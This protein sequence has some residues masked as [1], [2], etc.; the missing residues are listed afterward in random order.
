[1]RGR[2]L[3]DFFSAKKTEQKPGRKKGFLFGHRNHNH[4]SNEPPPGG[5]ARVS[6]ALPTSTC[7]FTTVW[8]ESVK[9]FG[10]AQAEMLAVVLPPAHQ[11]GL[12]RACA[13]GVE[14]DS[15]LI[16]R[17]F[18]P[19]V[20]CWKLM[21]AWIEAKRRAAQMLETRTSFPLRRL[22]DED[23]SITYCVYLV[24]QDQD[25]G[26]QEP[27][28][29]SMEVSRWI[30]PSSSEPSLSLQTHI[31]CIRVGESDSWSFLSSERVVCMCALQ[32]NM[33]QPVEL[34]VEGQ[35][36]KLLAQSPDGTLL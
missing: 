17:I 31:N 24:L 23:L 33:Q 8:I 22:P 6:H 16:M 34:L 32:M 1:M 36:M 7:S 3:E 27:Q 35:M 18:E 15:A 12:S 4:E 26:L 14:C 29:H 9:N 30:M 13:W 19:D 10:P 11:L 5:H 20:L 2:V 28:Q 25:T 21:G